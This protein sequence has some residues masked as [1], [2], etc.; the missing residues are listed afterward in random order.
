MR[1][2]G[3]H[4][5]MQLIAVDLDGSLADGP[6]QMEVDT[7]GAASGRRE[8]PIVQLAVIHVIPHL[9]GRFV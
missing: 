5:P 6:G 8:S 4:L 7:K 1:L 9:S 2:F 3:Q